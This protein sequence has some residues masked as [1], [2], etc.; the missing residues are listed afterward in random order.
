LAAP[1]PPNLVDHILHGA[2]DEEEERYLL[3]MEDSSR[4]FLE[5]RNFVL[6]GCQFLL[7]HQPNLL[8]IL[9]GFHIPNSEN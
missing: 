3:G 8:A 9:A 1:T 7:F 2:D 6:L 5:R 4:Y